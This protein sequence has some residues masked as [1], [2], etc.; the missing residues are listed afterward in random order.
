MIL[1]ST[2]VA[3]LVVPGLLVSFLLAFVISYM[4]KPLANFLERKGISRTLAVTIPFV[5]AGAIIVFGTTATVSRFSEQAASL[6]T[7]LP[8]YT[9]VI[10][11]SLKKRSKRINTALAPFYKTDVTDKA[12]Q[13]GEAYASSLLNT[14]PNWLGQLLT[15]L[16]LAPFFCFLHAHR[17]TRHQQTYALAGAQ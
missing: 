1:I 8:T 11:E 12:T 6:Q 2:F 4:F 7:E 15:T 10:S 13:W 3:V 16:V 14:V 5:V 9:K 17:R